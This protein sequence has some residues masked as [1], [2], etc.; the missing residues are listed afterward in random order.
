MPSTHSLTTNYRSYAESVPGS[1][2]NN[3]CS[4]RCHYRNH[5]FQR[6]EAESHINSAFLIDEQCGVFPAPSENLP[7]LPPSYEDVIRLP[8]SYSNILTQPKSNFILPTYDQTH[9][10]TSNNQTEYVS[11]LNEITSP[12]DLQNLDA[13]NNNHLNG[14]NSNHLN[15][16]NSTQPPAATKLL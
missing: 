14:N 10:S 4:Q 6:R 1:N 12:Q 9:L 11:A 5:N 7:D 8:N 2:T 3:N 13:N 16:N 15:G